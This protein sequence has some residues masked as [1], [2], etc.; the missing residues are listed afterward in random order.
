MKYLVG[1]DEVGRG[2]L[3]GP[4][5]VGAFLVERTKLPKYL[6]EFRGIKDSKQLSPEERALWFGRIRT[7]TRRGECRFS[8]AFVRAE[9]IDREGMAKALRLA[10]GRVLHKLAVSPENCFVLLDGTLRAPA[11]FPLQESIIDGDENE[12]LIATASIVA[13]VRRDK[14]MA[15]LAKRFPEYGF[16]A[17]KGYGTKK[18]YEALRRHGISEVHRKSFLRKFLNV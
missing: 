11:F 4:L 5:C 9:K 18:H 10:V 14:H 6:R 2:P 7:A 1:I 15:L 16:E 12:P 8:T 13:K 3:A 17:H